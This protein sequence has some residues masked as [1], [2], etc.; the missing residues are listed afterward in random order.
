MHK[1]PEQIPLHRSL[2]F[3]TCTRA[4]ARSRCSTVS[5]EVIAARFL[6]SSAAA[7]RARALPFAASTASRRST[8]ARS[9]CGHRVSDPKLNLRA[10]RQDVG[11]VFQS[12]NLFPHLTIEQNITLAPC[13]VKGTPKSQAKEQA[14]Q[15]LAQVGLEDKLHQYPEQLRRPAAACGDRPLARH[16]AQGHAVRRSDLGPRPG[17]DR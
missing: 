3:R 2:A 11:I 6:S 14:R 4:S 1:T 17:A 16:A 7:A 13:S 12:Y 5:F 10:L 9:S 15:V 8:A